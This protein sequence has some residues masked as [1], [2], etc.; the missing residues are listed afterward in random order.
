MQK[1]FK[2]G[3]YGYIINQAHYNEPIC[4]CT[5]TSVS[6]KYITDDK[7]NNFTI[8]S[9]ERNYVTAVGNRALRLYITEEAAQ[10]GLRRIRITNQIN[11]HMKKL[12]SNSLQSLQALVKYLDEK[13]SNNEGMST[14]L[15]INAISAYNAMNQVE[16]ENSLYMITEHALMELLLL[17]SKEHL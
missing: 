10:D 1:I 2:I 9:D 12:S 17:R 11:Q 6:S 3:Q 5:I 7:G 16:P 14:E 8:S 15:L 13:D 4:T